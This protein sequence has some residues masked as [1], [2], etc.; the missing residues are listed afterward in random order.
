M[1]ATQQPVMTLEETKEGLNVWMCHVAASSS[2]VDQQMLDDVRLFQ[3]A[4][5]H[6]EAGKQ[7]CK[8][9]AWVE[10]FQADSTIWS[11]EE[12]LKIGYGNPAIRFCPW[13]GGTVSPQPSQQEGQ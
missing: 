11:C 10:A 7:A 13:C 3:S 12:G 2:P 9:D 6:L 8:C 5:H 1:T 4:L